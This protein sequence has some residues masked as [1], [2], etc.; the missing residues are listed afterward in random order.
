MTISLGDLEGVA[1]HENNSFQ[2]GLIAEKLVEKT[3]ELEYEDE[4]HQKSPQ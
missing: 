2:L 4:G 1:T 3:M